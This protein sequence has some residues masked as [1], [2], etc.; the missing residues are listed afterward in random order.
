MEKET[1]IEKLSKVAK[2]LGYRFSIN[3][4]FA[5]LKQEDISIWI[6]NGAYS[7]R[8]KIHIWGSY[9]VDY[10]G[11]YSS[12]GIREISI[13]C[14][15]NKTPEQIARD[16]QRRFL[17]IYLE[18]LQKTLEHNKT[19]QENAD[20]K[21]HA[22]KILAGLLGKAPAKDHKNHY[23]INGYN[24]ID[25]LRDLEISHDGSEIGMEL[26][27]SL[28]KAVRILRVLKLEDSLDKYKEA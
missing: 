8:D 10:H 7:S 18:N 19:I 1:F 24:T 13:N 14:S 28:N 17:P 5:E 26:K 12:Y 11:D 3:D 6:E 25:C 16:I 20:K 23:T 9:P 27:L 22:V 15:P 21:Y 2:I 4:N